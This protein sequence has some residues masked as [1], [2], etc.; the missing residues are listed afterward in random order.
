M[1]VYKKIILVLAVIIGA[2]GF[3]IPL[4]KAFTPTLSL[5]NSGGD[6]VV[7][8]V[9]GDAN[10][11][12]QL[13]YNQ[14]GSSL[15]TVITN[16]GTTNSSGYFST[17]VNNSAYGIPSGALV[18]VTINGQQSSS[19]VWPV[20][21]GGCYGYNCGSGNLVL[22][23]TSVYL[24]V[25]Q[26]STITATNNYYGS[27][28]ITNNNTSIASV[29]SSGSSV[30][31][32]G[33]AI[34]ST[35]FS[36][37]ASGTGLCTSVYVTVTSGCSGYNCIGN[38][39]SL[40][41]NNLNLTVGQSQTVT[42]YGNGGSAYISNHTNSNVTSAYIS[43][44]VLN[45]TANNTGSDTVTICQNG[46]S[47]CVSLLV[48]VTGSALSL[49]QNSLNLSVG[50]SGTVYANSGTGS[51]YMASNSNPTVATLTFSGTAISVNA[52]TAGYTVFRICS[53]SSY[54]SCADLN[55]TVSG[56]CYGG[57]NCG[58]NIQLTQTNVSLNVGQ[59]ISVTAYSSYG[60]SG[61]YI[62]SNSNDSVVSASING[63]S[64]YLFGKN[65]GSA[66][67]VVCQNGNSNQ[68]STIYVNV[69]GS[70]GSSSL[71]FNTAT[72]PIPAIN[73]Y[74]SVQLQ[75][76]GGNV[77]YSYSIISG[78]LP[79]GLTLSSSGLIS[80]TP[81]NT[82]SSTFNVQASDYYGHTGTS[83]FTLVP[84]CSGSCVLGANTYA[85]GTLI[86]ENGTVY[87]VYKNSKSAFGNP[88]AFLG[89]GYSFGNVWP[90]NSSVPFSGYVV[91]SKNSPHPWGSWVKSGSTVYFVHDTGLIPVPD[92]NNFLNNG[93]QASLIVMANSWD[94]QKPILYTMVQN[95]PRLR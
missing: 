42:I 79:T 87:I 75:V 92:W 33:N 7:V 56:N 1:N 32:Y 48:N 38:Y 11:G 17:S 45:I 74:Y 25:G 72:L 62:S 26:T 53:S 23:Q 78:S 55:V 54:S 18:F 36:V 4:A 77:P 41:Q 91:N 68:C 71:Y 70:G 83:S 2:A 19:V 47:G 10:S 30:T 16:F 65:Y 66:N 35:S 51:L 80:G 12:I 8:S 64:I 20:Y 6:S 27:L 69:G 82:T 31:V 15:P 3:N 95:D 63:T 67:I 39:L 76:S 59:N 28:Y 84:V 88:E 13:S 73:Q 90:V 5:S 46:L 9:Y 14:S 57:Y 43:S 22:S 86:S 61:F 37:C 49:N 58:S 34:G 21:G 50:Q 93:G 29:S 89:L 44:N 85:N 60:Y 40:S 81:K 24:S 52:N 94:L